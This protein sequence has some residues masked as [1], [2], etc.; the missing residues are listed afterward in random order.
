MC[1]KFT[2]RLSRQFLEWYLKMGRLYKVDPNSDPNF[3]EKWAP[4]L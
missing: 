3:Q 2:N 1:L 4:G